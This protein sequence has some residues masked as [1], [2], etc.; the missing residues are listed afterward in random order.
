[1]YNRRNLMAASLTA[2]LAAAAAAAPSAQAASC[3]VPLDRAR[4]EK[5]VA[6]FNA[7]DPAFM[8]FYVEDIDFLGFAKGRSGVLAF[9]AKQRP[10][11]KE[12][13]ELVSFC[14]D[15][16]AAAVE[17]L[18]EFRCIAD[19]DDPAVFGRPLKKGMVQRT[20]GYMFYELTAAGL[21][22]KIKGPPPEGMGQWSEA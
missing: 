17:V 1:M 21:I 18:G 14:S 22:K 7:A 4:Y 20:H 15:A 10:Y 2:G 6:L 8:D 19:C 9:Y 11:V 3:G 16:G 5:Y 13:L 12:T